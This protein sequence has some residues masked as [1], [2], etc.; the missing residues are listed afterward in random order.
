[1]AKRKQKGAPPSFRP[2]DKAASTVPAARVSGVCFFSFL[3]GALF[4]YFAIVLRHLLYTTA[5][6]DFPATVGNFGRRFEDIV[7]LGYAREFLG[8]LISALGAFPLIG[9]VFPAL[10]LGAGGYLFWRILTYKMAR[11]NTHLWQGTFLYAAVLCLALAL[12]PPIQGYYVFGCVSMGFFWGWY[13]G[14]F[15]AAFIGALA[16][17]IP[18]YRKRITA[19]VIVTAA[20]YPLVGP[21]AVLGLLLALRIE[22]L[23]TTVTRRLKRAA[24]LLA[25]AL[26]IPLLWYPLF[27]GEVSLKWIY[28]QGIVHL[29]SIRRDLTTSVL[30]HSLTAFIVA[31]MLLPVLGVAWPKKNQSGIKSGGTKNKSSSL[32]KTPKRALSPL[33][34]W[35]LAGVLVL[36]TVAL[37]LHDRLFHATL[38]MVRPLDQKNWEKILLLEA[39]VSQ[40]NAPMILLRRLALEE[41][42]RAGEEYFARPNI[43]FFSESIKKVSSYRIFGPEVLFATGNIEMVRRLVMN[44]NVSLR[45]TSPYCTKML[46][47]C[48]M[49]T[50]DYPL[51]ERYLDR[52]EHLTFF[53]S[54]LSPYREA[55]RAKKLGQNALPLNTDAEEIANR[56]AKA[57]ARVPTDYILANTLPAVNVIADAATKRDSAVLSTNDLKLQLLDF[58]TS[59]DLPDFVKTF[60]LYAERLAGAG[61]QIPTV[62]QQGWC[63]AQA[64][65]MVPAGDN[66]PGGFPTYREMSHQ[67]RRFNAALAAIDTPQFDEQF[68]GTWW[69]YAFK[70]KDAPTY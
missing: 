17:A 49:A 20:L 69:Y 59:G 7:R 37:A 67:F 38:A 14:F 51:A 41:T 35:G 47:L 34:F 13:L 29:V 12:F 58:L 43:P 52:W 28:A 6:Y 66:N 62:L 25:A 1:M 3:T 57:A 8:S 42:G 2:P 53:P 21:F 19:V 33:A 55:L 56:V 9:G 36:A 61:E 31:A 45:G 50:G 60:P 26:L 10:I 64:T 63:Y 44:D 4:L 68:A 23:D 70:E 65:G 32:E 24:V 48:A 11:E 18:S 16:G 30:V 15:V 39:R 5:R 40:P 46:Y 54:S 22:L 27:S